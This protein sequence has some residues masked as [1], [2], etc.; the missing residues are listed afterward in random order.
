MMKTC[1]DLLPELWYMYKGY[2]FASYKQKKDKIVSF[3][4]EISTGCAWCCG[5][6]G[7]CITDSSHCGT[8]QIKP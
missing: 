5:I 7:D 1:R 8:Y 2:T 6:L 4:D 3:F